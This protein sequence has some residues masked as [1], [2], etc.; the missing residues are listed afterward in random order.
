[1]SN[2]MRATA[3]GEVLTSLPELQSRRLLDRIVVVTAAVEEVMSVSDA[4]K[5]DTAL[6]DSQNYEGIVGLLTD[7]QVRLE[8]L[9]GH[10]RQADRALRDILSEL[11]K[12]GDEHEHE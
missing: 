4:L 12:A 2:V 7:L 9:Q 6:A 5:K 3:L 1:M 8:H 11:L 10:C